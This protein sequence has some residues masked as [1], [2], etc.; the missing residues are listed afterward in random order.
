MLKHELRI[1]IFTSKFMW[2]MFFY[3]IEIPSCL[4]GLQKITDAIMDLEIARIDLMTWREECTE[5]DKSKYISN[6]CTVTTNTFP[7]S[8]LVKNGTMCK[9][10]WLVEPANTNTH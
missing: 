8:N 10:F 9:F 2:D 1:G 7:S 3:A 6:E 4:G 5:H